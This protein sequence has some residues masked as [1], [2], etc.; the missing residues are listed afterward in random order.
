M[1]YLEDDLLG[2]PALERRVDGGDLLF[3]GEREVGTPVGHALG[4]LSLDVKRRADLWQL[5]VLL[6]TTISYHTRRHVS[7]YYCLLHRRELIQTEPMSV[8]ITTS[9]RQPNK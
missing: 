8:T 9:A 7:S 1:V 5:N 6:S 2:G 4:P 3:A